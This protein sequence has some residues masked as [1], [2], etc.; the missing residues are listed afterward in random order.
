MGYHYGILV[1]IQFVIKKKGELAAFGKAISIMSIVA[2]LSIGS[3]AS[4]LW[5]TYEYTKETMRGPDIEKQIRVQL[6]MQML[7]VA[8]MGLCNAMEQWVW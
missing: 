4:K 8:G 5:T 6:L 7:K 3:S 2:I 1:V